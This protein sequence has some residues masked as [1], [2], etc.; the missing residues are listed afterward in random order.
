MKNS[1]KETNFSNIT[2]SGVFYSSML[3]VLTIFVLIYFDNIV[4]PF[5]VALLI[6]YLIKELK[7]KLGSI[8][9]KGKSMSPRLRGISAFIIITLIILAIGKMVAVNMN[10]ITAQAPAYKDKVNE[11]SKYITNTVNDPSI[12][13]FMRSAVTKINFGAIASEV[14]DSL[15]SFVSVFLIIL[16]YVIFMLLEES[17]ASI[18]LQKMFP[19]ENKEYF[20]TKDFFD[21]VDKAIRTYIGSMVLISLITAVVS[22][23]A[24][25][26]LGVDFPVLWAFLVFILNFIPYIGPF[27]S[28]L[29]PALLAIFQF[30][31][32]LHFVYVF[33]VLEVIQIILGNFVQ[34]KLMGKSLN[35]SA[36]TVLV[37]LAFWGSI[38]GIAGMVLATPITSIMIIIFAR[39]PQTRF[40]SILMSENGDLGD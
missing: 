21:K 22:Y 1:E 15:S 10:E 28:S 6:W 35:M 12:M 37:T 2:L 17:K 4:K 33:A 25:L 32:M 38:W 29:L 7:A 18:K 34:P 3:M 39:F 8:K 13:D 40:I 14:V 20:Q 19:S 5:V 24:L 11:L 31:D 30:G 26:I 36:L 23:I 27:I 16:I 9:I